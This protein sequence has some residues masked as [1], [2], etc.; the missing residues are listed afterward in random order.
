LQRATEKE[1]V[2]GRIGLLL[3]AVF[4]ISSFGCG[5][6]PQNS[7]QWY[8]R[9]IRAAQ[10]EKWGTAKESLEKALE[11]ELTPREQISARITLADAYFN[12]GD[13][14]N[15]AIAYEEFLEL[16]PASEKA[17]D[18]LFNLGISYVNLI[19]GP[20]WDQT[21]TER[22][23]RAFERFLRDYPSDPRR[24]DAEKMKKLTKMILAEHVVYIGGTY[25]MIHKFTA[26]AKRYREVMETYRDVEP[27]DR[28]TYLYGRALYYYPVQAE[29]EIDRLKHSLK[30]EK[31][32]L[33]SKDE[34]E[35]KIAENRIKFIESDIEMW[36]RKAKEGKKKG[37]VV[38]KNLIEKYPD[39]PYSRKARKILEGKKIFSVEPVKNPLK[40]SLWWK[41]WK[42]I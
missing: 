12:S 30:K 23:L 27:E 24:E 9:G 26:S 21:F 33:R 34:E 14:E 15:A 41:I 19:K 40:R 28:I 39:S 29:E 8:Q 38:L 37:E 2:M 32:K 5:R 22:A 18:A 36:K 7:Q 16:Y 4:L 10:R 42:T 31:K 20:E 17:K 1:R 13:Y 11:G 6:I 3:L 35:R 25:D